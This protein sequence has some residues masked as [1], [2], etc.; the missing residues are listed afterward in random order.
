[1]TVRRGVCGA[2]AADRGACSIRQPGDGEHGKELCLGQ[3]D[4]ERETTD[5]KRVEGP[6][7]VHAR[8]VGEPELVT[9]CV[10]RGAN[11]WRLPQAPTDRVRDRSHLLSELSLQDLTGT[12]ELVDQA[13]EWH[14]LEGAMRARMRLHIHPGITKR[15]K[16]VPGHQQRFGHPPLFVASDGGAAGFTDLVEESLE[17]EL[18]LVLD[19]AN[20]PCGGG[21]ALVVRAQVEAEARR[22]GQLDRLFLRRLDDQVDSVPPEEPPLIDIVSGDEECRL[23]AVPAKDGQGDLETVLVPV[24]E[25][26]KNWVRRQ[27]LAGAKREEVLQLEDGEPALEEGQ[28]AIKG[29]GRGILNA[30]VQHSARGGTT[31]GAI[32]TAARGETV[33]GEHGKPRRRRARPKPEGQGQKPGPLELLCDPPSAHGSQT[34]PPAVGQAPTLVCGPAKPN[35]TKAPSSVHHQPPRMETSSFTVRRI[36]HTDAADRKLILPLLREYFEAIPEIDADAR[37]QWLY[38]DNPAGLARTYAA[39]VGDRAVGI[40][41]LFPRAVQV[42]GRNTM[43]AIGGD[44]YVTPSFR[45]RGV[46][47]ALHREAG[48]RM[49]AGLSCMFGP[50]EPANLRALLRAGSVVTGAVRRYARPLSARA[51]GARAARLPFVGVLD[52]LL[53]PRPSELHT[54]KLGSALDPRVDMVWDA[55]RR[56]AERKNEV[57]PVADAAFY[58]WRFGLS[59]GGRQEGVLVLDKDQPVGV[60]ALERR[61]GR[62]AIVDVSCPRASFRRVVRALVV[63][64]AATDAVD[65]QIHIPCRARELALHTLGFVPRGTK[66]FQVQLRGSDKA[67][68]LL[69]RPAAWKYMWGDGDLEHVL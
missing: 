32:G 40:T 41:S 14:G 37:Y 57:V 25:R 46:V 44:G 18:P 22:I 53:R 49:D 48:L 55:T 1:V 50:P 12:A 59:A 24:I 17:I 51:L 31:R 61:G 11:R 4:V 34:D 2:T 56:A 6:D 13:C 43:G 28:L 8:V 38:V 9:S 36:D 54:E 7:V 29:L 62:S 19:D 63:S 65:I 15:A 26:D 16:V 45:K 33:V 21:Q 30:V 23:D 64:L 20:E 68:A 52:W 47:T 5:V 69:T 10:D 58:A 27:E 66:P 60:A 42:G 35:S 39:C 67:Q 3:V